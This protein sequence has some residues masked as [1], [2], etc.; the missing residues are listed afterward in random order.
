MRKIKTSNEIIAKYWDE[1][2][3]I[4]TGDD[5]FH[6]VVKNEKNLEEINIYDIYFDNGTPRALSEY[7]DKCYGEDEIAD[8]NKNHRFEN[9]IYLIDVDYFSIE[10]YIENNHYANSDAKIIEKIKLNY[11]YFK[12]IPND[13]V[14]E[15]KAELKDNFKY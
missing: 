15:I 11:D 6:F 5:L 4:K 13:I 10:Y 12:T 8:Y 14:E 2:H 7:W 3:A 9:R 1:Y